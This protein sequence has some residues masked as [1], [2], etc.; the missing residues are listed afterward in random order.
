MSALKVIDMPA[1]RPAMALE[2]PEQTSF[3]EWVAIGRR[4]CL[5]SHALNWHIGDWWAFGDHRYGDRAK[6]AAE[7]IF[8]REFQT[9]ANLATVSRAV[10]TSRRRETLTWTHHAEVAALPADTAEE[11]LAKAEREHLST[12]DLRREVQAIRASNDD[13]DDGQAK[14]DR[15][16][17]P[18]QPLDQRELAKAYEMVVEFAEALAKHRPLHRRENDMLSVAL[19]YLNEANSDR[20][21]CPADFDIIFVEQGRLAC[22][23]WYRASRVTVNRWLLE[24]GK[25][26]LIEHRAEF[27]RH[28]RDAQQPQPSAEVEW[29]IRPD[30]LHDVA[31]QAADFLRISRY[32]GWRITSAP[33]GWLVGTVHRTS[34]E[35]IAMAERQGFD[36]A[37][38][39]QAVAREEVDS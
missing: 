31:K 38:A 15:T 8:G 23:E 37:A 18:P 33:G 21:G 4:L 17:A 14:P 26:R 3:D 24:R 34:E 5:S 1:E 30:P 35:L 36:R 2:L 27:V 19:S 39:L 11:L 13:Q 7:G 10:E 12:R 29:P 6:A 28:Q 32:G 25:R 20:R 16:H 22:E 9:L